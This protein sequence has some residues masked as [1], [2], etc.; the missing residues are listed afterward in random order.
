MMLRRS[1]ILAV[2]LLSCF[3]LAPANR[4][5]VS[6]KNLQFS[7]ASVS[8]DAGD[9][10]VWSNQDD[11]DHKIVFSEGPSSGNL[12]P[13]QTW[14]RTFEKSGTFNYSC[15]YRPRMKGKVVVK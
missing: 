1:H 11:R 5:T 7:P 4:T 9:S 14:S 3:L 2:G 10:V 12:K 8:I 15:D 13:G 6:I